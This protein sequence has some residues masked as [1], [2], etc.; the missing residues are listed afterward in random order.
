M[1]V[2]DIFVLSFKRKSRIRLK[3]MLMLDFV[4]DISEFARIEVFAFNANTLYVL[5]SVMIS[6]LRAK[7]ERTRHN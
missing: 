6:N 1:A 7:L 4:I 2:T 5:C 3:L